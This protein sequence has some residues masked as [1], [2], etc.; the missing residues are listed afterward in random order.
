[1]E[2]IYTSGIQP[3]LILGGVRMCEPVIFL[4]DLLMFLVCFTAWNKLTKRPAFDRPE[5][6]FRLFF[7]FMAC[8][9]II[10]GFFGHLLL[11]Y[12]PFT[13]KLPGWVFSLFA[14]AAL[15]Q[16]SVERSRQVIKPS[17]YLFLTV[18]NVIA[19]SAAVWAVCDTLWF[20]AVEI[21]SAFGL[22][23]LMG[24]L[25]LSLLQ[26][27]KDQSSKMLLLGLPF[28]LL[29]VLAH[30]LRISPG[31]WFSFFDIGHVLLCATF[32]CFYLGASKH[33]SPAM[34]SE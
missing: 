18:I 4:T 14:T 26:K 28:A 6:L 25:E 30:V 13:Y 24:A 10:S 8:S 32:Y 9:A 33:I 5:Q 16:A 31:I 3:D 15:A 20:P 29:A 22:L 7:V 19:L 34:T 2:V 23:C 1:M 21:Y 17:T 12:V 27:S 11:H